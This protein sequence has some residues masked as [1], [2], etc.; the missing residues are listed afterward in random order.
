MNNKKRLI[1]TCVEQICMAEEKG[2][3]EKS[4]LQVD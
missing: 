3:I 1:M 2:L 4:I